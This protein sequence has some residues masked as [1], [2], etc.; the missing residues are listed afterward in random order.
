MWKD[1][2]GFELYYEISDDGFV[3]S[4]TRIINNRI[5]KGRVLAQKDI[6]GYKNVTLCVNNKL[7]TRQVHRLV[8]LTYKYNPNHKNLQVNHI[9]GI[10]SDNRL[11][12]LEWV[13]PSENQKHSYLMKLQRQDGEYNNAHKLTK[14]Q[15]IEIRTT[16]SHLSESKTAKIFGVSRSLINLI[17]NR[18][19]WDFEDSQE[20][21][22]TTESIFDEKDIKE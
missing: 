12:N 5:Y 20:D 15:V 19:V 3:R 11:E 18:K 16:Y 9:N 4:K 7:T 6:R 1:L 8:L 2:Y 13:T 22:S 21:V 14:K 10:K 17:R